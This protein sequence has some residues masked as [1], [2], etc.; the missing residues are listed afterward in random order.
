M[1][2]FKYLGFAFASDERQDEELDVQ[3]GK[4]KAVMRA[5]HHSVA[6]KR[7]LLRRED[8]RCLSRYSS[9]SSPMVISNKNAI[10]NANVGN[11]IFAKN[12]RCYDA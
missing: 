9:S 3:S 7:K 6:I 4:A 12:Q 1:E 10:T 11:E 8:S 5:L 2:K